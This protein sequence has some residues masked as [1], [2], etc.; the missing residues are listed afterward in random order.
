ME[1]YQFDYSTEE[2]TVK[3]EWLVDVPVLIQFFNRPEQLKKV[4]SSV[5]KA[6]PSTLLLYQDGARE[7]RND[8][9]KNVEACR[10]IVESV[11]WNCTVYRMYQEKNYGCDPSG[12]MSR[13]WAFSICDRCIVLEDDVVSSV[14][15]FSFC[16]ELLDRYQDDK[17]I[18]RISGQNIL[19]EYQPYA[20]D[21]FF[22]KGGSIWGWA[23]WKR[24]FDEWDPAYAFLDDQKTVECLA[25]TYQ[26][27][28]NPIERFIN[29]CRRHRDSGKEYFESI[30]S[31]ARFLG[32][33]LT[34]VP[35]KNLISNIGISAESTHNAT[36]IRLLTKQGQRSF[37]APTYELEFPLKHPKFILEDKRYEDLQSQFMGWKKNGFQKVAVKIEEEIRKILYSRK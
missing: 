33:G 31:S 23:T 35:C 5:C 27:S 4:F 26:R 28:G 30:Y 32:T 22:T 24:V 2:I 29:K 8:D 14:S 21:Y 18:Y 1:K 15:F 11:D 7:H 13:K 10:K 3:Q 16:K 12:Y 6:K 17:R 25:Y 20:G 19:G 34:I 37:N 9:V 36:D